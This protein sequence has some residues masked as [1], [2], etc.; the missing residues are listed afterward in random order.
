LRDPSATEAQLATWL[1]GVVP[2]AVGLRVTLLP[3][4]R[5]TGFSGETLLFDAQWERD[6]VDEHGRYVARVAPSGYTLYQEHDLVTQWRVIDALSRSTDVPVP[7]I[8]GHD[9]GDDAALGRPFFVM[10]R[11]DGVAPADNPPFTVSGWVADASAQDRSALHRG[12]LEVLARIHAVDWSGLGLGFLTET[13]ASPV[14]LEHALAHDER[15]LRWVAG[16]RSLPVFEEAARWM[17]DHLPAERDLVLSWGDARLGN[18]LF[19]DFHPVA[20]LDWEMVTLAAPEADLGWWLVFDRVHTDG[21]R[22]PR[23]AGFLDES[24]AIAWYER[25][26]GRTVRDLRFYEVRAAFRAG[27]LLVRY[28]DVMIAEG[29]LPAGTPKGPFTPAVNVLTSLL[30]A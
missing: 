6:G 17:R 13:T 28:T 9:T 22:K 12:G 11:I 24:Q 25:C 2:G 26:S 5:A 21:I 15:F 18:M 30:S 19:A 8:I 7:A 4:P 3:S 10:E 23:P 1:A 14:G 20:V 29:M 16:E 27:L